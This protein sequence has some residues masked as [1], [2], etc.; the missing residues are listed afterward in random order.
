M[1]KSMRTLWVVLCCL[2][3][4]TGY[5]QEVVK[6]NG[7]IIIDASAIR[8]T[9]VKKARATD[10]T[11]ARLGTDDETNI[12]SA[13][14]D[15]Q[16]YY[17]FELSAARF[18]ATWINAVNRCRNLADDGGGWR[19]PTL[20]E[21]ILIYILW[22]ELQQAGLTGVAGGTATEAG[23][24]GN[25]YPYVRYNDTGAIVLDAKN[26]STDRYFRCIRDLDRNCR[27][28]FVVRGGWKK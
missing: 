19:L 26:V 11:N 9:K 1:R 15:E 16:V 17:R 22:P 8:H 23:G 3:V 24:G 7:K 21:A 6:E 10:G 14:S 12:G 5:A 27:F 28:C 25:S 13:A 20:K 18:S 2:T 4:A